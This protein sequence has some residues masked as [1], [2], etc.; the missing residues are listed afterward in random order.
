MSRLDFLGHKPAALYCALAQG[1][2]ERE[3]KRLDAA[4]GALR[5][6]MSIAVVFPGIAAYTRVQ[7][8]GL[9][10]HH[11]SE[12]KL[13]KVLRTIP[14]GAGSQRCFD[15]LEKAQT[16]GLL[17]VHPANSP[18]ALQVGD[19]VQLGGGTG[20]VAWIMLSRGFGDWREFDSVDS[21]PWHHLRYAAETRLG[22]ADGRCVRVTEVEPIVRPILDPTTAT[23][24]YL[25][26]VRARV[27][28]SWRQALSVLEVNA[29]SADAI[30]I[31][32]TISRKLSAVDAMLVE[33]S[34]RRVT[35]GMGPIEEL[36]EKRRALKV[37]ER[38]LCLELRLLNSSNSGELCRRNARLTKALRYEASAIQAELRR[39]CERLSAPGLRHAL[40][41]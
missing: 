38:Q 5:M 13:L 37:R 11:V 23:I 3:E 1:A 39:I 14:D 27:A 4:S 26:L 6:R 36:K 29:A 12:F 2:I 32:V 9:P 15:E 25:R 10:W 22:L 8:N 34:S 7:E 19:E 17:R 40:A 33:A 21:V 31:F 28:A 20:K 41:A 30:D 35:Q 18:V 16:A 24:A